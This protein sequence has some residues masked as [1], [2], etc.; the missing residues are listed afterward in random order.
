KSHLVNS[1]QPLVIRMRND[2]VNKFIVNRYKA[3]NRIV[4]YFSKGH[5]FGIVK[6]IC[7]AGKDKFWE[8]NKLYLYE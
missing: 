1:P 8:G 2:I 5:L 6:N 3:I 7:I 4:D